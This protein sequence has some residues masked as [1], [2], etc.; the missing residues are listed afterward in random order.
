MERRADEDEDE[1]DDRRPENETVEE[2]LDVHGLVDV[3]ICPYTQ[4][5]MRRTILEG[6][7]CVGG[8]FSSDATVQERQ[9]DPRLYG[10][11]IDYI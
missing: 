11:L 9:D 8:L 5:N 2:L 1:D 7:S 6:R 10:R 3:V 4:G